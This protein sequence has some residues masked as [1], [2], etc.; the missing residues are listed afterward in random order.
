M[1]LL[2]GFLFCYL[3]ILKFIHTHAYASRRNRIGPEVSTISGSD[4]TLTNGQEQRRPRRNRHERSTRLIM[5][6]IGIF[7]ICRLPVWIFVVVV[8]I[9]EVEMTELTLSLMH[10]LHLLSNLSTALSPI[11]YSI[12]NKSL[13]SSKAGRNHP[14]RHPSRNSSFCPTTSCNLFRDN[15]RFSI[16]LI[17]PPKRDRY[18][19]GS[20][21]NSLTL[22]GTHG[23][24]WKNSVDQY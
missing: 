14:S 7:C 24:T 15:G 5:I 20:R 22:N 17:H 11:L 16:F 9:E 8:N 21:E 19:L 2:L 18:E 6:L 3:S 12:F 4:T 10:F 1:T 13:R 23:I